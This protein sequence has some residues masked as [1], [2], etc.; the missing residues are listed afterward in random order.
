MIAR[1]LSRVSLKVQ[2]PL[3]I[4]LTVVVILLV[5]QFYYREMIRS[6]EQQA[7]ESAEELTSQI[8]GNLDQ[9]ADAV[10]RIAQSIAY[11]KVAQDYL[12]VQLPSEKFILFRT[13]SNLLENMRALDDRI[14]DIQ[15]SGI[16][17][18]V[19]TLRGSASLQPL[20]ASF[21][22]DVP[23]RSRVYVSGMIRDTA[24]IDPVTYLAATMRIYSIDLNQQTNQMIGF[25][26]LMIDAQGLIQLGN[27]E[28]KDSRWQIY[29]LDRERSLIAGGRSEPADNVL[30]AAELNN[31]LQQGQRAGSVRFGGE[32][33]YL[34]VAEVPSLGI[35]V[36][37]LQ[38]QHELRSTINRIT[39]IH[40]VSL[41]VIALLLSATIYLVLLNLLR[42]IDRLVGTMQ[43]FNSG[44][45]KVLKEKVEP[46]AANPELRILTES[47]NRMLQE[48]DSLTHSLSHT[49]YRMYEMELEKK[50]AELSYLRSQINPH[51]L[52]N[53]LESIKGS[54][55]DSG[56]PD[57][58]VMTRALAEM[59]RYAIKGE[60]DVTVREELDLVQSYLRI[61][62]I[63]F[64]GRFEVQYLV[65]EAILSCT[66]PKMI[67]QPLLENAISHGLEQRL[68]PGWVQ[69]GG[70]LDHETGRLLLWVEDNGL[71][72]SE[73]TLVQVRQALGEKSR[74]LRLSGAAEPEDHLAERSTE[75][76]RD[77]SAIGIGL[78]NVH[79]RLALM[80][81]EQYGLEIT[82]SPNRGT[83]VELRLPAE[84]SEEHVPVGYH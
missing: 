53:T 65:D 78:V 45:R 73:D 12:M 68:E 58:I 64:E 34:Q 10:N 26:T 7:Y 59:F 63:R 31:S 69:I 6:Y 38:S 60:P 84:R 4:A 49:Y 39:V 67:L 41:G 37:A 8:A 19:I 82:S 9:F 75:P 77:A 35:T 17:G 61:Q 47:F 25:L 79:H 30:L 29:L 66:V 36:L 80:F 3:Y 70:R 22:V 20:P 42:P 1:I 28:L 33:A 81:G 51:F 40:Y 43:L 16:N 62:K 14:L 57:I 44:N 5:N 50:Q 11:N 46:P 18:N 32:A 13:L 72:M 74:R 55:A 15:L 21:P 23:E 24:Q 27:P 52:F 2:L 54:A 71:G 83:R 76:V 56:N 48:I